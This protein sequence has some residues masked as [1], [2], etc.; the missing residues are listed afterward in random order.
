MK[1]TIKETDQ[2]K[3]VSKR[4]IRAASSLAP[5]PCEDPLIDETHVTV[6]VSTDESDIGPV[7]R[8]ICVTAVHR[9]LIADIVELAVTGKEFCAASVWMLSV[10]ETYP[11]G[12]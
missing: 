3:D 1:G 8:L 4:G 10:R 12:A 6:S 9:Q 11:S 5:A 7:K 2:G